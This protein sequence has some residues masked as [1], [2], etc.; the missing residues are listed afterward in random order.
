MFQSIFKH[1]K[2]I[3]LANIF[4]KYKINTLRLN[5]IKIMYSI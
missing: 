2:L 1:K 5:N 3:I 4:A